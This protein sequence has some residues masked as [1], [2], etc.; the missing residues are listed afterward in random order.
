MI[1]PPHLPQ[2]ISKLQT[3]HAISNLSV[4][5]P[6]QVPSLQMLHVFNHTISIRIA[7][8]HVP[9]LQNL[10]RRNLGYLQIFW[11]KYN[12]RN[13]QKILRK[14]IHTQSNLSPFSI[15]T[16]RQRDTLKELKARA[17]YP[18]SLPFPT[19]PSYPDVTVV[20]FTRSINSIAI[21]MEQLS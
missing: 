15:P 20:F 3:A 17:K 1:P 5:A 14:I 12:Q 6:I 11:P 4:N 9:S 16:N 13:I 7:T 8:I 18:T 10:S 2:T 19:F 21:I